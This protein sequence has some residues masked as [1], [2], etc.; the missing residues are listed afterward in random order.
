MPTIEAL[1]PKEFR[2]ASREPGVALIDTRSMLAFG[3]GHVPGAINIGNRD[4]LSNWIGQ[5]FDLDQQI[6][7]I[8]DEEKDIEKLQRMIVR[9]GHFNFPRLPG[10]RHEGLGDGWTASRNSAAGIGQRTS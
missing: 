2:A 4:E 8:A 9:T 3:G 1:P 5:L 10:R 7:L 6:L